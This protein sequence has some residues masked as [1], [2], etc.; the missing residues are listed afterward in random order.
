[1]FLHVHMPSAKWSLSDAHF[2]FIWF[3][4]VGWLDGL[5]LG[6]LVGW[7][8]I[9]FFI[10]HKTTDSDI[11]LQ[12]CNYSCLPIF[13]FFYSFFQF[14]KY[15]VFPGNFKSIRSQVIRFPKCIRKLS[16]RFSKMYSLRK[17]SFLNKRIFFSV[18][19]EEA[20]VLR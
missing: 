2:L 18:F 5:F 15:T 10:L 16:I 4:S 20:L 12:S 17:Y 8:I 3:D 6:W 9:P 11:F 1:M 7:S 19:P 13:Y 14:S